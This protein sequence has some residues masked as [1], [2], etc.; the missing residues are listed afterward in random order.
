M[1][2]MVRGATVVHHIPG[3]LRIRLPRE[4]RDPRLLRELRE[5]VEGLGGVRQVEINP[6]TGSILVSYH[7][8]SHEQI[9]AILQSAESAEPDFSS[10]P[11]L[12]EA[13]ELAEQIEKEA[14]FL[15]AH[16]ELALHIVNAV[17]RVNREIR[18]ASGNTVDLK[19]LVPAGFAVW[20]FLKAGAEIST[21]LWVTLSLFSFNSFV[22]LHRPTHVHVSTHTTAIER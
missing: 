21:P 10:P 3:R 5:F 1:S 14:E 19:V 16:S 4:S 18:E 22:T 13:D 20:A 6:V 11:E 15:A 17:K 12:G 7:P 2:R 9:Q 8:E